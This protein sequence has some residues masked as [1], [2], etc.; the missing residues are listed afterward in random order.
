MP[1][2][3]DTSHLDEPHLR[4][5]RDGGKPL[6][7]IV[8]PCFNSEAYVAEAIDSALGQT[9]DNIEV[10]VID[11]GS[12][13]G[14]LDVIRSYEGRIAWRT[15]PNEGPSAAR[16]KGLALARGEFIKFLDADDILLPECITEQVEQSLGLPSSVIVFGDDILV[17]HDQ[18]RVPDARKA[19]LQDGE[20]ASLVWLFERG[21]YTSCPLYRRDL[22]AGVGGFRAGLNYAEEHD[23]NLRLSL[24]G[25][26]F[27]Y[28]QT[29]CYLRRDHAS[30]TRL[31]NQRPYE[32]CPNRFDSVESVTEF[33][34]HARRSASK[35]DYS[36]LVSAVARHCWRR[37]RARARRGEETVAQQMFELARAIGGWESCIGNRTYR[38]L[39]RVVGPVFAERLGLARTRIVSALKP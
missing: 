12:S 37:G 13:D 14:S 5:H 28:K 10:I 35:S 32:W 27:L 36:K 18:T 22:L 33:L 2:N 25:A 7:S 30:A 34:E 26:S 15:G 39:C 11:D 23:M 4:P 21:A 38:Y 24:A 16:N 6:V 3:P 29:S 9:Y 19:E 8:M 20:Y 1:S 31:T 17:F